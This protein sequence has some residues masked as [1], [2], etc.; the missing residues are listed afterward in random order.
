MI[1]LWIADL[2]VQDREFKVPSAVGVWKFE[3]KDNYI[4]LL[5]KKKKG[6]CATTFYAYNDSI[7][8]NSSDE[9]FTKAIDELIDI[10]LV[11][12]FLIGKCVTPVGST[13]QSDIQFVQ[14]GDKFIRARA[15]DGFPSLNLTCDLNTLFS[16]GTATLLSGFTARRMELFLSHWISGLTCFTL[17]D[18]F[19]SVGVQMDIVKQCEIQASGQ[20]LHYFQGMTSAST[21]YGINPL[22]Q[23]YKNMRNDIVHEGK[24][25]AIKFPNK[26]KADCAKVLADTLNWIDEYTSKV[27]K[28]NGYVT[29]YDR[30]RP[31][32]IE[33]SLPALSFNT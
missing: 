21:R 32:D 19:L 27:I 20:S 12:S 17:E 31:G 24:L 9:D 23:D 1:E 13:P 4:E 33:H 30:W 22:S 3:R 7:T 26:V 8:S 2:L 18:M 29:S 28:I 10:C 25:S 6:Q 11:L 5:N 15:I 16:S 14:L